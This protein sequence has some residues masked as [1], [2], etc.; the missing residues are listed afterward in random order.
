MHSSGNYIRAVIFTML[1]ISISYVLNYLLE[2]NSIARTNL[3][4]IRT[5]P[6][7]DI[8][9]GTSHGMSAINPEIV[10]TQTGRK[11]TNICMPDEHLIDS[12]YLVEE[13]FR[14]NNPS[15]I[16]Y[17][18]DPSY[19]STPQN[20]GENAVYVYDEFPLSTVKMKYFIDKILP[21]DWRVVLSPWFYYRNRY[22]Q[23]P[24]NIQIKQSYEYKNFLVDHL[25]K[26]AQTYTQEGYMYQ[27]T[28]PEADKGNPNFL[29]WNEEKVLDI[30]HRY[31]KKII[32]LCKKQSAEL[33]VI[34]T[35][36]SQETLSM[37]PEVYHSANK[38]F[39]KLMK[40]YGIQYWDFN[41]L[42]EREIHRSIGGYTDYE[43]HMSGELGNQ[44][45]VI[46]GQYLNDVQRVKD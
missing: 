29:L 40:Y 15:R 43:G 20:M 45:S 38:Y 14:T 26:G 9:I 16:I 2:P 22:T 41:S 39:T 37:Y 30:H 42:T 8:F 10:D 34:T 21:M 19:W 7:D 32:D 33:V 4:N 12:Y 23:I 31:L 28:T 27:I 25:S 17:E 1:C 36:V 11:S 44:F 6:Y 5:K 46:L 3:Y 13:I 24:E 18:L 35:P